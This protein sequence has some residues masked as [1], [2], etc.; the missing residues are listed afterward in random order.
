[1]TT[2]RRAGCQASITQAMAGNTGILRAR[3][4]QLA[5]ET[6]V[7]LGAEGALNVVYRV[8]D[9]IELDGEPIEFEVTDPDGGD[10]F[11]LPVLPLLV[12]QFDAVIADE[13]DNG[14]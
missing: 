14:S 1:M 13:G 6:C 8:L 3:A 10:T 12:V 11:K 4:R 2:T 9:P 7:A 5:K